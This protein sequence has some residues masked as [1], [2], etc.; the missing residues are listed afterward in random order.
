MRPQVSAQIANETYVAVPNE[1]AHPYVD[2]EI[3][4]DP[5]IFPKA[6]DLVDAEFYMSI[7]PEAQELYAEIWARF[8]AETP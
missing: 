4:N 2:P 8:I 5:L 7:S 1:G 6:E 3:L